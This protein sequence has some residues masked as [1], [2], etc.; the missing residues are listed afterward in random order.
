MSILRNVSLVVVLITAFAHLAS[1]QPVISTVNPNSTN[2]IITEKTFVSIEDEF[3]VS[4]SEQSD[5]VERI[6]SSNTNVVKWLNRYK[7]KTPQTVYTVVVS[8]FIRDFTSEEIPTALRQGADFSINSLAEIGGKLISR[9]EISLD[10]AP[11]TEIKMSLPNR[12]LIDR[13]FLVKNRLYSIRTSWSPAE[14]GTE[15][16]KILD[17]FKLIDGKAVV[18]KRLEEATPKSLPQTPV[19]KK[20]KTDAQDDGLKGKVKF[21]S[22]SQEDLTGS[23]NVAGIKKSIDDFYDEKG[24]KTKRIFYDYKGNPMTIT[25]Y[26]YIDGMRVS[27]SGSLY[28]EYNPPIM[29]IGSFETKPNPLQKPADSRYEIKYEYKYDDKERLIETLTYQ[30]NGELSRRYAYSYEGNKRE[31]SWFNKDGKIESK[32]IRLFDE[33]SNLIETTYIHPAKAY[34][35]SKYNYTYDSFDEKGNWTKRTVKAKDGAYG[36]GYKEQNYIE[37]RKITYYP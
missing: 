24:S 20:L 37:Y 6:P 14:D 21:V 32:T 17:S 5:S 31:E 36:G 23:W 29:A 1:G 18:A 27:N 26:G 9:K 19:V 12:I 11:G 35:D 2:K 8:Y 16:L 28:F 13:D 22:L 4:L 7:W 25:V 30:N 33:K 34:P 15:Q 10:G 3:A